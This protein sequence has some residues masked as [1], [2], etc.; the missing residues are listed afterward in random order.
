M[1]QKLGVTGLFLILLMT[2]ST[3]AFASSFYYELQGG[4][5]QVREANP[6]FGDGAATPSSYGTSFNF[7]FG[8]SFSGGEIPA[9]VQIGL[10]GR[11]SSTSVSNGMTYY[12]LVAPYPILR[13]QLSRIYVGAGATPVMWRRI[14]STAGLDA[15]EMV[16]GSIAFLGEAGFLWPVAPTFSLGAALSGQFITTSGTLSPKPILEATVVLRFYFGFSKG[17]AAASSNEFKGWRYP[18]GRE[19]RE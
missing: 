7:S 12:G 1:R 5:G 15:L 9:E 13:L 10:Q 6:F 14:G 11:L 16:N 2:L 18:F 19:M 17:G 8:Y 4:M 3:P